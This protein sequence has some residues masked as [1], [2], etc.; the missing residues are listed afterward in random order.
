[1]KK[2][3]ILISFI[4][5]IAALIIIQLAD[6][7]CTELFD[8]IQSLFLKDL[9]MDR[10][11]MSLEDA[12]I[13]I[14][15]VAIPFYIIAALAPLARMLVDY[16]GKEKVLAI[17]FIVLAAGCAIC[18]STNN[19]LVFLAGNSIISFSTSVDI[20]YIYIVDK[21]R[22]EKRATIRGILA[23]V[24]AFAAML[25]TISRKFFVG[26]TSYG[27]RGLYAVG[28]AA[29]LVVVAG[30]FIVAFLNHTKIVGNSG[31]VAL[32]MKKITKVH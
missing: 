12:T 14:N 2:S 8:R 26:Y 1:M 27:W 29:S 20:Q 7:Y 16:I 3:K 31:G 15:S 13:L 22:K 9:I 19:W 11:N 21:V 32:I 5:L 28:I 17:N 10:K 30:A 25:V 18:M 23:A 4:I 24:A 6:S